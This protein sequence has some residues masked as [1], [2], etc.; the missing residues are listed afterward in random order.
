VSKKDDEAI[1]DAFADMAMYG[2]GF[3]RYKDGKIEHVPYCEIMVP[4]CNPCVVC[5]NKFIECFG[6]KKNGWWTGCKPCSKRDHGRDH[7]HTA[8]QIAGIERWNAANPVLPP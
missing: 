4:K 8:T 3:T 7:F 6:T 2:R 5:G 1:A